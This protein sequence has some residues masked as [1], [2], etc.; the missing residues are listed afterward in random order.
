[1]VKCQSIPLIDTQP[2]PDQ[3]SINTLIDTQ[4]T[5]Q[6]HQSWPTVIQK[7]SSFLIATVTSRLT[8]D[9]P[10]PTVDQVSIKKIS[11]D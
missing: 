1:M 2:M 8:L 10:R 5:L 4:F 9:K 3:H 7:S 6:Q 11:A